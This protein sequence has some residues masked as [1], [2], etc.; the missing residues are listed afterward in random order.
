VIKAGTLRGCFVNTKNQI[1]KGMNPFPFF[2][3]CS[4]FLR[5]LERRFERKGD[6]GW[7]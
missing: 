6:E 5:E 4:S 7:R 1:L 2:I 3:W